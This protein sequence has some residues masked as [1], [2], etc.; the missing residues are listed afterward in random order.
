MIMTYKIGGNRME[1]ILTKLAQKNLGMEGPVSQEEI[2]EFFKDNMQKYSWRLIARMS[3]KEHKDDTWD[4]LYTDDMGIGITLNPNVKG[5]RF[6]KNVKIIYKLSSHE[7][8]PWDYAFKDGSI[9]FEKKYI[10]FRKMVK[11]MSILEEETNMDNKNFNNQDPIFELEISIRSAN[12]LRKAGIVSVD[13]LLK[14]DEERIKGIEGL[15][16]RGIQEVLTILEELKE[17]RKKENE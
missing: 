6:S 1:D 5:F 8:N 11:E 13:E 16:P 17:N 3:E 15:S 9:F 2:E 14:C 10:E 4:Y 12:C 7:S